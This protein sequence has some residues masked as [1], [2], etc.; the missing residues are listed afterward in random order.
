MNCLVASGETLESSNEE[1]FGFLLCL[2]PLCIGLQ[3]GQ[4]RGRIMI[5]RSFGDNLLQPCEKRS[6][7]GASNACELYLD[8]VLLIILF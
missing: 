5:F 2:W 1:K 7:L 4:H 6:C 8:F 3:S